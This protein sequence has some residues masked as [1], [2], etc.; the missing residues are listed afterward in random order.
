M[1]YNGSI[2][3]IWDVYL[4]MLCML[5]RLEQFRRGKGEH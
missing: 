1:R 5:A 2:T 4:Y 3:F